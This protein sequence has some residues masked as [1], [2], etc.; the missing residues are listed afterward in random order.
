MSR[1]RKK[2]KNRLFI[3]RIFGLTLGMCLI[4]ACGEAPQQIETIYEDGKEVILNHI[5][6]YALSGEP[7]TFTCVDEFV[8][9]T[10]DDSIAGLGLTDIGL[11]NQSYFDVDSL[12]SIYIYCPQDAEHIFFK[13]DRN[14]KFIQAFGR[15]GQGPGEF[16]GNLYFRIFMNDDGEEELVVT[17][18]LNN[19]V[20]FLKTDGTLIREV[21]SDSSIFAVHPLGA[22]RFLVY[23]K[24]IN[25]SKEF[26]TQQPLSLTGPDFRE[27]VELD[28][29]RIPNPIVG[30]RLKGIYYIFSWD[31]AAGLV[32]TGFQERGYEIFVYNYDGQMIRK[33]R[34]EFTPIPVPEDHKAAYMS[35]FEAEMYAPIRK[36]IYFP[37]VMP[38][39][40]GFFADERGFLLVMTYEKGQ[41]SGEFLYDIFNPDGVFIGR[42]SLRVYFDEFGVHA[43]MK[44]GFLYRVDEKESG[45]KRLVVSLVTWE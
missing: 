28:R 21:R 13:F 3:C 34:K 24:V 38:P 35:Q 27:M 45:F 2:Q 23:R 22:E 10:E 26:L 30:E 36:K 37:D 6:P 43:K 7:G 29:Q 20:S 11:I 42:K 15:K 25:A 31:A 44:N 40:L 8:I 41:K 18:H 9:D 39:F 14:G 1:L 19:R 33:I 16:Q 12:G 17:D 32:F 4:W 5:E